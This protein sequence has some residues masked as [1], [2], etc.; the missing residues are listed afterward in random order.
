MAANTSAFA[1]GDY[2]WIGPSHGSYNMSDPAY[3][4]PEYSIMNASAGLTRSNVTVS[5]Y[6][7]NLLNDQ[8]IIQRVTIELLED[9][10]VPRPRTIGV[11]FKAAF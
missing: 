2:D 5:V 3:N 7:K 8:K 1:A 9:A 6:A 10:Y 11:Q 4:Y